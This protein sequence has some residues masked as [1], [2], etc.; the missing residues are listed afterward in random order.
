MIK[1]IKK[2][3]F[4]P[5]TA[6]KSNEGL[7]PAKSKIKICVIDFV[8][9]IESNC[10]NNFCTQ[11]N[12]IDN[13]EV[14]HYKEPLNK[15][16]L[17]L[18]AKYLFDFIDNGLDILYKTKADVLI[19]GIRENNTIRLHF[20]TEE[21]FSAQSK[22]FISILDCLYIPASDI[23][24]STSIINL[25]YGSILATYNPQKP[26]LKIIKKYWL[27]KIISSLSKDTSAKDL[28]QKCTP[29]IMNFLGLIYLT[30][31]SYDLN[32]KDYKI[33]TSLFENA[34]DYKDLM[35]TTLHLGRIYIHL[36]ELNDITAT[37]NK[38]K[39]LKFLSKAI[40]NYRQAQKY[41]NK[42]NFPYDYGYICYRLSALL[43][44]AFKE[45]NDIQSL[46]DSV[47]QLREAER[48]F[49]YALFPDFWSEIQSELGYKLS[50]LGKLSG[51]EEILELAIGSYRNQQKII[52]ERVD[53]INWAKIQEKIG[54]IYYTL[55]KSSTSNAFLEMSLEC[56][57]DA[58]YIF[59]N[60]NLSE[61][62][63]RLNVSI[64]KSSTL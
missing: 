61:D 9:N 32:E 38:A 27:K 54:Q 45:K 39:P 33:T 41:E 5:Q 31:T 22:N 56:F 28:P 35:T 6:P 3:F 1:K 62:I 12:T 26:E 42:Y 17:N 15:E 8:D 7:L 34:L 36:A 2:F 21:M 14:T 48:I 44:L 46:R 47:F 13:L 59:E 23:G 60:A 58:L 43:F 25:V 4:A 11:L 10:A 50:L 18:D 16:F 51:S 29:Y 30:Y 64:L 55:G 19:W 53:A 49:T 57:H 63:K 37:S 24:F 52:T 20:Q 40:E